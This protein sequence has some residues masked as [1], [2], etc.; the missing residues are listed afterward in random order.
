ML[1]RSGLGWSAFPG[2]FGRQGLLV[3]PGQLRGGEGGAHGEPRGAGL[4][5]LGLSSPVLMAA[6]VNHRDQQTSIFHLTVPPGPQGASF[7]YHQPG[8]MVGTQAPSRQPRVRAVLPPGRLQAR[9]WPLVG[10]SRAPPALTLV[11]FSRARAVL[12]DTTPSLWAASLCPQEP[13]QSCVATADVPTHG[14]CSGK[15]C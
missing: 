3:S 8:C 13:Q 2:Y 15:G 6:T 4:R 9:P 1:F 5:P 14:R 12:H 10:P 11:G 7:H